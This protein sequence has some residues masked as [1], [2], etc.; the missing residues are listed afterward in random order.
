MTQLNLFDDLSSEKNKKM[1]V[2]HEDFRSTLHYSKLVIGYGNVNSRTMIIG[3]SCVKQH[4][5]NPKSSKCFCF[6]LNDSEPGIRSGGIL[7][8]IFKDLHLKIADYYW[9]N[10]FKIPVESIKTDSERCEHIGL[11]LKEIKIINPVKIIVMGT[12]A[13]EALEGVL[14][15]KDYIVKHIFH[16]AY[17][18][19]N[20]TLYYKYLN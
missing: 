3:E 7:I 18:V 12:K 16:P 2:L 15:S 20:P 4:Y 9:T 19:R 17:Y 14:V 11:L 5:E 6:D 1:S 10:V 8:K 13:R